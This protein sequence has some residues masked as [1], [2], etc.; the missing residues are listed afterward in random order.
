MGT[1][2]LLLS[3]EDRVVWGLCPRLL[4]EP[5]P[6]LLE[7]LQLVEEP[8]GVW[9][10]LKVSST[11]VSNSLALSSLVIFFLHRGA[12]DAASPLALRCPESGLGI[13]FLHRGAWDAASPLALRCPESGLGSEGCFLTSAIVCS[14][15]H[16]AGPLELE[17]A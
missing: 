1:P 14:S 9:P 5:C 12:W 7:R 13:F 10:S 8:R 4:V 6:R 2:A 3:L 16:R 11:F 15:E 17:I